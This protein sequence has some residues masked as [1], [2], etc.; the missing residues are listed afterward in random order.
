[1]VPHE[2]TR[3]TEVEATFTR[4]VLPGHNIRK[5]GGDMKPGDM[6]VAKGTRLRGPQM[7]AAAAL[8]RP[9]LR[10]SRRPRVMVLSPGEELV[11][12]GESLRSGQIR[13]SNAFGL[14]GALQEAGALPVLGPI[15][16]DSLLAIRKAIGQAR[17]EA[18]DAIITTGGVSAGDFDFVQAV[19]R[20]DGKPGHV[21]KTAMRP[22]KPLVFGRLGGLPLFG[23]PGNPASALI[24]FTV[25]VLPALRRMLGEEPLLPPC[26]PVRFTSDFSYRGG[27]VFL[28]RVRVEPDIENPAGGFR[29]GAIGGQDSSFLS[30]L[31][32]ANALVYL[33]ADRDLAR[34]GEVF[35][36]QWIQPG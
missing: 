9:H 4:P 25:F 19:V 5:A 24:S 20:E 1:V 8:G 15:I 36:A 26:F 23:L 3:F 31:A 16:S 12:P 21:F 13:N 10:A 28:L 33:P 7:A 35:P 18:A 22:G 32:T 30:S 34:A 29:I 11:W 27:R 17:E 2:L 6:V 14:A